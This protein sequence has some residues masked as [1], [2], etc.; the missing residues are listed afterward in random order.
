MK[1]SRKGREGSKH[2]TRMRDIVRAVLGCS[3]EAKGKGLRS[4]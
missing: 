2:G 1:Q 3:R 4:Q